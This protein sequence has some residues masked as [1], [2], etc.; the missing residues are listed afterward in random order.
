MNAPDGV[1]ETLERHLELQRFRA[2]PDLQDGELQRLLAAAD[3]NARANCWAPWAT[4]PP[5]ITVLM[6]DTPRKQSRLACRGRSGRA[7]PANPHCQHP[8]HRGRQHRQRHR[9]PRSP[10][11][12]GATQLVAVARTALHPVGLGQCQRPT[13]CA[14]FRCAATPTARI[15]QSRAEVDADTHQAA[16]SV[17]Y[18]TGPSY[19]FG[20]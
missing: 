20:P 18:D 13:A 12:T 15:A 8:D 1:R 19:R 17:N 3:A 11:A 10:R 16:L 7:W 6:T 2:L 9:K 14:S 4:L 5:T